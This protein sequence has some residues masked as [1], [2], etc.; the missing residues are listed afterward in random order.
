LGSPKEGRAGISQLE[1]QGVQPVKKELQEK[2]CWRTE[3]FLM[4]LRA[5]VRFNHSLKC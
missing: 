1:G 3:Y 2:K 4:A 5:L